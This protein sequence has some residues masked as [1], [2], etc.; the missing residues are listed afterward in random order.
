M[1]SCSAAALPLNGVAK[2]VVGRQALV[3]EGV[4]IRQKSD[5]NG[6]NGQK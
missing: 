3:G 2:A 4:V 6:Q 5:R 1:K